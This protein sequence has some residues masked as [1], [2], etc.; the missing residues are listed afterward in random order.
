MSNRW[1]SI[2]RADCFFLISN[3]DKLHAVPSQHVGSLC[4]ARSVACRWF[5]LRSPRCLSAVC[6]LFALL[7]VG[8]HQDMPYRGL[9]PQYGIAVPAFTPSRNLRTRT[10]PGDPVISSLRKPSLRKQIHCAVNDSGAVLVQY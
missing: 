5:A 7:R 6:A 10:N 1:S 8:F 3:P 2:L 9:M 4:F